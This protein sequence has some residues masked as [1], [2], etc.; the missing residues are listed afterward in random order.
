MPEYR[1]G[2]FFLASS[3]LLALLLLGGCS[4]LTGPVQPDTPLPTVP[5]T[6]TPLPPTATL[7]VL[8][9][10]T[11]TATAVPTPADVESFPDP[12]GYT[13]TEVVSG[14]T[15]PIGL[16]SAGDGSGRL[17]IIEQPGRILIHDGETLLE[18]PY[19]DIQDRVEDAGSEQGLLGLAF[20]PAYGENGVFFV[21]YINKTGDSVISRFR[22]STNPD[23]ADPGSETILLTIPQPFRNHNGGQIQFGPKGYLWIAM[24]DGGSAGDPQGNGQNINTLLGTLLRIDIDQEPYSIPEDNPFGNEIWAYGLRNPWRF[25][26]DPVYHDLYIADVGQALWEEVNYL[27]AD[28]PAGPNF[29]WDYREGL[30]SYEGTPPG[31]LPLIDPV[32]EYS[33]SL[34]CSVSGGAVY[35]GA[36]LEWQG[37]YLYGDFCSGTVWGLFESPSGEWQNEPLFQFDR[38]ITAIDQDEAGEIYLLDLLGTILKLTPQ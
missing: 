13:W 28:S 6:N 38:R 14:L 15:R 18:L 5:T 27:P 21:S 11:S 25:T 4:A 37:I 33:H 2:P 12:S 30:H 31:D 24:G 23:Q 35:R 1:K 9:S 22:E 26:F 19:L 7:T 3:A 36:M 17:F 32:T 10:A 34:G 20:H 8:P 16:T 29:G